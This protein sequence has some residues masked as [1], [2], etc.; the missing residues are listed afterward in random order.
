MDKKLIGERILLSR[1]R[2]INQAELGDRVGLAQSRISA[3]ENGDVKGYDLGVIE[4]IAD[5]LGVSPQ[6]LVGWTD[7]PLAGV[8][9]EDELHS[10]AILKNE[11]RTISEWPPAVREL[12]EI[13]S[14]LPV[15]MVE[16]LI[17]LARQCVEVAGDGDREI[18]AGLVVAARL[19]YGDKMADQ[20]VGLIKTA[21]DDR[22]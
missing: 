2:L 12:A 5:V 18:L 14:R 22:M 7:D 19:T 21:V 20:L 10:L 1:R 9:D 15:E 16:S 4:S 11:A 13:A 3:Y 8:E 17:A 6:Y